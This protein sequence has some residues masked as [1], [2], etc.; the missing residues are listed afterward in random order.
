MNK[1]N[2]ILLACLVGISFV[3]YISSCYINTSN[4]GSHFAL[5]SSIVEKHTTCINDYIKYTGFTDY[6]E[7]NG[8]Y[9]SDRLPGTAILLIPFYVF[10]SLLDEIGGL[11]LSSHVPIQEVTVILMSNLFSVLGVY[12]LYLI[13]IRFNFSF[14]ISLM[15]CLLY[16][17][18][19]LN[20]QESTHVFS[21]A[22]SMCFV[23]AAFYFL[24]KANSIKD[25]NYYIFVSLLSYSNIIELQNSLLF[26]PAAI[27]VLQ[28]NKLGNKFLDYNNLVS[29]VKTI[30]IVFGL[31]SILIVYNYISFG[32]IMLKSNKYNPEFPEEISFTSSLSGNFLEGLDCLFLN[33]QNPEVI[34]NIGLGVKNDI[35]GLLITS[36]ILFISLFGFIYFF[37]SHPRETLLFCTIII[38]NIL[39]AAF[40]KTVLVRHVFTITPFLFFPI[41]FV[42]QKI[43][44]INTVLFKISCS[45]FIGL[46]A[47]L[48]VF[49][50]YYVTHT[51]WGREI[52]NPFPFIKELP[53]YFCFVLLGALICFTIKLIFP[54]A[55]QTN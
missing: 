53:I 32:E 22:A 13:F 48:S 30:A 46:L 38:I 49:R 12:F 18:S 34:T 20:W 26:F 28:S 41:A 10:G 35:P 51:Y 1:Q 29:L 44:N 5:V 15:C 40:H 23:L 55:I 25:G 31:L 33:M 37:K 50:V 36:P 19:T 54:K 4:D 16:A 14:R 2:K 3:Y 43:S 6:A 7:K 17:F 11:A 47:I 9:Y 45:S 27:Y 42:F 39:I 8:K 24:L 52:T 21:H